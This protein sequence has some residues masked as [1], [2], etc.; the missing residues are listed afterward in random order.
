MAY[1]RQLDSGKWQGYVRL[2]NGKKIT[3]SARLKGT[4][5]EWAKEKESEIARG[6]YVD[7][8]DITK[9][10][11]KTWREYFMSIRTVE[12]E[13]LRGDKAIMNTHVA[14]FFDSYDLKNIKP[15]TVKA[16]MARMQKDEVGASA[17]VRAFNLFRTSMKLAVSDEL[18]PSNPAEQVSSP[19][20]Q[21]TS[22]EWFNREQV[23]ALLVEL[24]ERDRAMTLLMAWVGLRWGECAGLR[25]QD[26]DWLRRYISVNQV[27]TQGSRIKDYPKSS[28]SRRDVPVPSHVIDALSPFAVG[29]KPGDLFFTTPRTGK[30]LNGPNWRRTF[31]EAIERANV[32]A[33][34]TKSSLVIPDYTPHSLRHTAASWLVQAGVPLME[35]QRLLGHSTPT[36]T[37]RYAHL[38]P[39]A[40]SAV[41]NAW[42]A[43]NPIGTTSST[44][45]H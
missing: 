43:L 26:V 4:I 38:A 32:T 2:P 20:V 16:W 17:Q 22:V 40:H 23:E 7:P 10:T 14:P 5:V 39:G 31:S 42:K 27:V 9:H 8:A 44:V 15:S 36:M 3:K 34:K 29:K 21:K 1:I 35:V 11:Y 28:A 41:E 33:K 19:K 18:I 25:I 45:G 13:T 24:S 6:E 30:P 37:N 12:P